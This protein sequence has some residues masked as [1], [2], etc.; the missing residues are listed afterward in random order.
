MR[1]K[2]DGE[3]RVADLDGLGKGAEGGRLYVPLGGNRFEGGDAG[4]LLK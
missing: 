1:G 4:G 2:Y 3:M